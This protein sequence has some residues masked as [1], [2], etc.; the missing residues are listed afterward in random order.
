[1]I[2]QENGRVKYVHKMSL[3]DAMAEHQQTLMTASKQLEVSFGCMNSIQD[4]IPK[5]EWIK[6]QQVNKYFYETAVSR[7]QT[8]IKSE[9]LERLRREERNVPPPLPQLFAVSGTGL[10]G[11]PVAFP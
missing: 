6:L 8:R 3:E 9:K 11:A 1:M 10:F 7:V 4:F 5:E 2:A